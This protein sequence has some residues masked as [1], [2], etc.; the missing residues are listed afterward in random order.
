MGCAASKERM[1]QQADE[2]DK[3]L[4]GYVKET[5]PVFLDSEYCEIVEGSFMCM[6][7]FSH[8]F[9]LY[10]KNQEGSNVPPELLHIREL[11]T[12]VHSYF[13]CLDVDGIIDHRVLVGVTL[14]KW[15]R[16]L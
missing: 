16:Y 6:A 7:S 9:L 4:I 13:T 11:Q 14:T 8:T 5:L 2:R 10:T 15:P 3:F 12:F 1:Q